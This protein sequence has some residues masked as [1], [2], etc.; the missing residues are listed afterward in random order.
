M[1][2]QACLGK[3]GQVTIFIV[4]GVMVVFSVLGVIL[5][6]KEEPET[7]SQDKLDPRNIVRSC[8]EDVLGES[9]EKILQNGG[10]ITPS[11][12]ISYR[13]EEWNYLCYQA[14][15]YQGCYNTHPM[16]EMQIEREIERDISVGVQSCFN[17]MREDYE[18]RGYDVS[19]GGTSY[20]VDLV[21]GSVKINLNKDIE[22]SGEM[23][24]SSFNDFSL[25]IL[26]PIYDLVRVAREVVNGESQF[27]YFEY[28]GYMLLYPEYE[29][30]RID[31]MDSKIYIVK[32][33]W[34]EKE[35]KF[36]VRSCAFA[37][38]V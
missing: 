3:K 21:P 6:V 26:S 9:I 32:D 25:E 1:M 11:Q 14:D 24:S 22:I 18:N 37:P 4:V 38:G 12:T 17:S 10:E 7:L 36:A 27:C 28:N 5:L 15:F 30:R 2:R 33:R 13:G 20:S 34:T 19:G 29:I 23:G 16:L 31:Y 8:V 35:F